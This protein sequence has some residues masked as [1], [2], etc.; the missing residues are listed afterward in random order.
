MAMGRPRAFD[1]DETL[2]RALDVFWRNGYEGSSLSDL[3]KAM[4]INPPSLYAAFGNKEGLFLK[5]FDR[6]VESYGAYARDALEEPT[7]RDV[8][9]KL[10]HGVI[11]LLTNKRNP[12]GC[13]MVAT[14]CGNAAG[15]IRE[16]LIARRTAG[17]AA[18]RRRFER[19]KA[20]GDLP[21]DL[22]PAA[23]ARYMAMLLEGMAVQAAGGA[24]R[25]D[26]QR[27]AEIALRAWPARGKGPGNP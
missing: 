4:G 1:M 22:N 14:T 20:E 26:L 17:L 7:A 5:A 18:M 8:A 19:A 6:Y 11:D 9:T 2:D 16:E 25:K 3:T 24:G 27:V 12:R 21:A 23:A 10:L 13:L 15:P